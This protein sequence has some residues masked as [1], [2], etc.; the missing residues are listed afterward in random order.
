MVYVHNE[1][2]CQ[3]VADLPGGGA[4]VITNKDVI[5]C[6]VLQRNRLVRSR[7]MFL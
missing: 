1:I 5:S 3:R 4:G 7:L 2:A 6:P